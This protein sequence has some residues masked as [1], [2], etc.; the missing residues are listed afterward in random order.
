MAE[1]ISV[2][3]SN[4]ATAANNLVATPGKP[5]NVLLEQEFGKDKADL[6]SQ[7]Y[8]RL[9]TEMK[10]KNFSDGQIFESIKSL[11]NGMVQRYFKMFKS[12]N[13]TEDM[14]R[15][16]LVGLIKGQ[17]KSLNLTPSKDFKISA[18]IDLGGPG[19]LKS[20]LNA[21]RKDLNW[22]QLWSGDYPVYDVTD[23]AYDAWFGDKNGSYNRVKDAATIDKVI[24]KLEKEKKWVKLVSTDPDEK[25]LQE[26]GSNKHYIVDDAKAAESMRTGLFELGMEFIDKNYPAGRSPESDIQRNKLLT[27]L[28]DVLSKEK[29]EKE[30]DFTNFIREFVLNEGTEGEK[31]MPVDCFGG[32]LKHKDSVLLNYFRELCKVALF[33]KASPESKIGL[34]QMREICAAAERMSIAGPYGLESHQAMLGGNRMTSASLQKRTWTNFYGLRIITAFMIGRE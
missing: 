1:D 28:Y 30:T 26:L 20:L 8:G 33:E 9:I 4:G 3:V 7:S 5:L 2:P 12:C 15:E 13:L 25:L 23:E 11:E 18:Q 19:R 14:V 10:K 31:N 24:D 29:F 16:W 6:A 22:A 17:I 32:Q 21:A 34:A 27:R